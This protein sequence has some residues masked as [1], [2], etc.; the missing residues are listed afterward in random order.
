MGC[1]HLSSFHFR[2]DPAGDREGSPARGLGFECR[3]VKKSIIYFPFKNT[4]VFG[5]ST[6]RVVVSVTVCVCVSVSVFRKAVME[7]V[8]SCLSS[9]VGTFWEPNKEG[10]W[11]AG[12]IMSSLIVSEGM[13]WE[14]PFQGGGFMEM[15]SRIPHSL[16]SFWGIWKSPSFQLVSANR[17]IQLLAD[18]PFSSGNI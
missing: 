7:S 3:T 10:V 8:D 16:I 12:Q 13:A 1:R 18:I 17:E 6:Y 5:Q 14:I 11:V 4:K 15:P 2:Y 9:L